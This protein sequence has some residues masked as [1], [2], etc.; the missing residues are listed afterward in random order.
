[1]VASD[2]LAECSKRNSSL[3]AI[4]TMQELTCLSQAASSK[5]SLSQK[6]TIRIFFVRIP[7]FRVGVLDVWNERWRQLRRPIYVLMVLCRSKCKNRGSHHH[8]RFI[9]GHGR[10]SVHL[11][12]NQRSLPG[13]RLHIRFSQRPPQKLC[14]RSACH[15]RGEL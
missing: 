15:M 2:A 4:E 13:S 9:L 6:S 7:D 14:G 5:S 11:Q 8:Q 1:M 3:L 12:H 10:R